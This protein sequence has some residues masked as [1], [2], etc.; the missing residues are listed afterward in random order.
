VYRTGDLVVVQRHESPDGYRAPHAIDH[1]SNLLALR[2]LEV[3]SVLAVNSTGSLNETLEPGTVLVPDDFINPWTPTTFHDDEEGHGVSRFDPNLRQ[4]LIDTLRTLE[5]DFR[6]SGIYLQTRGPRFETPAEAH[7][8]ADYADIIGMN[9]AS[10]VTLAGELDLSYAT[11]CMIDN[12]VNGIV[13]TR[14][15]LNSFEESVRENVPRVLEIVRT[16]LDSFNVSTEGR[17]R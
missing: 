7:M 16:I 15:D 14:V 10:E 1:H 6:S 4:A 5:E 13:G 17:N 9:A 11:V 3:E 12:Y 8:F 2:E